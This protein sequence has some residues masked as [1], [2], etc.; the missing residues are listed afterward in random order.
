MS[1]IEGLLWAL[2]ITLIIFYIHYDGYVEGRK[3]VIKELERYLEERDG[4]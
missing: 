4:K 1:I 3:A 2:Y